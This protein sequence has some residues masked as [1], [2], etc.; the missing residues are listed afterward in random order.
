MIPPFTFKERL[1][2]G[3]EVTP[4][5]LV[6]GDEQETWAQL[7]QPASRAR[8]VVYLAHPRVA[9][10]RHYLIPALVDA[11]F[12]VFGHDLRSLH[13][14]SEALQDR[15]LKDVAAGVAAARE[16]FERVVLLGNSGGGTLLATHQTGD[17]PRADGLMVIAAHPGEGRWLMQSIDPSV[18]DEGDP[19]SCDPALD[20]FNP[21]NGYDLATRSA[22]YAPAF[23]DRYRAAQRARVERLDGVARTQ[24][25]GERAV[26]ATLSPKMPPYDLLCASRRAIP[27]RLMVIYRTVANPAYLDLSIDPSDRDIGTIFGLHDDRPEFGNYV[28]TNIA[29]V[30]S[31]RAWLSSWSGLSSRSDFLAAAPALDVPVLFVSARGDGEILPA[32]ADAMWNAIGAADR[33]RHD[34]AGADHYFRPTRRVPPARDPRLELRDVVVSWL[35]R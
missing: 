14:D 16:R 8:T 3:T 26:R 31:P 7:Y 30:L 10:S 23:L 21:E 13:N 29:R 4:I 6:S 15:L 5:R 18:T 1:P 35:R 17:G 33:T 9:F 32:D 34:V 2:A 20:M 24:I 27:H 12:A 11:G 25:A 28:S 19:L 22:R